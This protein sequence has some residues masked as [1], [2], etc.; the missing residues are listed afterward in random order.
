MSNFC[1]KF[2]LGKILQIDKIDSTTKNVDGEL[3]LVCKI[4][5]ETKKCVDIVYYR[6]VLVD[7]VQ[8]T[9]R[10]DSN[11]VMVHNDLTIVRL[12]EKKGGCVI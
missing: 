6:L 12:V 7:I 10:L 1:L 8:K 9:V 4:K 5:M 3:F 2:L 11:R